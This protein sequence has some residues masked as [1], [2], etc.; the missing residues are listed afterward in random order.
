MLRCSLLDLLG[1]CSQW[2]ACW[3]I[4]CGL[5]WGDSALLSGVA[6]LP[7]GLPRL[8]LMAEAGGKGEQ[9]DKWAA[10]ITSFH[11]E[12]V[13]GSTKAPPIKKHGKK[14]PPNSRSY[15]IT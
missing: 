2:V 8:V 13:N 4:P 12:L 10:D 7:G 15:T 1:V 11:L 14:V 5:D 9:K 6:H 3:V